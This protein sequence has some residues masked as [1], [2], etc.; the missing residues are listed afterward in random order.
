MRGFVLW[1]TLQRFRVVE[2]IRRIQ[3]HMPTTIRTVRLWNNVVRGV[4]FP[5]RA[6]ASVPGARR[7][8]GWTRRGL[9]AAGRAGRHVGEWPALRGWAALVGG[10]AEGVS[11]RHPVASQL[12]S[13]MGLQR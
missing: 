8:G 4:G 10:G 6:V 3:P 11:V 2:W 13:H 9:A 12:A 5:F 7:V 1:Q